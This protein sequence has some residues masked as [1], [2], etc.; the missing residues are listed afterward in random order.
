M[1]GMTLCSSGLDDD[2]DLTPPTPVLASVSI[3]PTADPPPPPPPPPPRASSPPAVHT[4][5]EVVDGD[6]GARKKGPRKSRGYG[7][8]LLQ[9]YGCCIAGGLVVV[10][11]VCHCVVGICCPSTLCSA[12]AVVLLVVVLVVL[13]ACSRLV[14]VLF[15]Q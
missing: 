15:L 13:S 4:E 1:Y 2:D 5:P 3:Q 10:F 11:V 14:G 9:R 6:Q 8:H 12:M 7:I